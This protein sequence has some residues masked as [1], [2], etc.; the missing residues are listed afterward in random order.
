[1]TE[2]K[3][4][5]TRTKSPKN[6]SLTQDEMQSAAEMVLERERKRKRRA[7][8]R[9]RRRQA[10]REKEQLAAVQRMHTSI[11]VIKW[12]IVGITTV[13][14]LGIL[15]AIWTLVQ[16]RGEVTKVQAEVEKVQPHVERIVGEVTDIV[17]EV[18]KVRESLRH[19]M[20]T[21]GMMFG[22]ELDAK[23]RALVGERLKP[24]QN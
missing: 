16:V 3:T 2:R 24:E 18:E 9:E 20:E 22:Q 12:C 10:Q 8:V 4:P 11:E 15:L 19:P 6:D 5:S 1:M 13:M 23:L 7:A 14:V 21:V 17:D